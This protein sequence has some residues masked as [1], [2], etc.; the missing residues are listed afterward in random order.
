MATKFAQGLLPYSGTGDTP[1]HSNIRAWAQFFEDTLV[2][3]GGWAVTADTGQTLPSALNGAN[4]GNEKR[5]YRVY[6]MTD[7]L[8]ATYPV[9][10]RI[11]YGGG[12]NVG[13]TP[14]IWVTI[15]TGS[16]GAGTITGILWN[17]G[18]VATPSAQSVTN[19]LSPNPF[20]SYG[21]AGPSR[22]A[23]ALFI[24]STTRDYPLVFSIERTKNSQGLDSGDGLLLVYSGVQT[25]GNLSHSR[26]IVYAGGVQPTAELG[27]SY[28]LT[29][30]TPTQTFAPGDI[31]VGIVIHFKGIAQQPGTHIMITNSN[32]VSPEGIIKMILYNATRTYV[33]LNSYVPNKAFSGGFA[34][35][36]G[37]ARIL[38]RYD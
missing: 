20:S 21:S 12:T 28:I 1:Q 38:M 23:I 37:N 33:Q 31:G 4:T 29:Y 10:M 9:F 17:G 16:N 3:V 25:G 5:G 22:A 30:Q 7:P 18:S 19:T 27:L 32:D 26:Y 15:G 24:Q 2:A 13:N 14:A 36:D 34:Q 6:R 35:I 11:D 8:Q